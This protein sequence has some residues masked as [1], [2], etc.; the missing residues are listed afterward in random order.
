MMLYNNLQLFNVAQIQEQNGGVCLFRYPEKVVESLAIPEFDEH[1]NFV[2]IYSKHQV[3]ARACVGIEIRF[4]CESDE[5]AFVLESENPIS[6]SVYSG[7]YQVAI[8]HMPAGRHTFTAQRNAAVKGVREVNRFAADM[9]RILPISNSP[10]TFFGVE[11]KTPILPFVEPKSS[12]MLVYGSSISQGVGA[13]YCLFPYV[14]IAGNILGY[15]VKNK[16]IA[17]GCFC[18][19]EVL[20]YLKS[21]DFDV[22]YFELGTNI[23]NRPIEIIEERV[24]EFIDNFCQHFP[25]KK[26]F[27]ATPVKAFDD[28]S[29]Q[30]IPYG[31]YFANTRKVITERSKKYPNTFLIDG[32]KLSEKAYYLSSD[33]LHPSG[34]GHIMM[35][36]ELA[37]SIKNSQNEN[38]A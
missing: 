7:D 34:F 23:A 21:E 31:R 18:E 28:V 13:P 19:K 30:S 24:G 16:A 20:E 3:S 2:Q 4:F 10:V 17:G 32:H 9:W 11:T 29:D 38:N 12:T 6:V 26:L 33:V 8:S 35:G 36:V 27:F 37:E 5:I 14:E 1:D 25:N 15:Q 22:A